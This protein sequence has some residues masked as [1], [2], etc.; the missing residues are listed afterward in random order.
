MKKPENQTKT[1]RSA[2]L[3]QAFPFPLYS[4]NRYL[5]GLSIQLRSEYGKTKY[6]N[7]TA[8]EVQKIEAILLG[9]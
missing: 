7:L 4:E 1:Y 2:E 5:F 3:L 8:D 6:L 9:E